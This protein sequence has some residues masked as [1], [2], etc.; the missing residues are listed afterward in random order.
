MMVHATPDRCCSPGS[1]KVK[2]NHP[3]DCSKAVTNGDEEACTI[4]K[5][6]EDMCT[7]GK[8]IPDGVNGCQRAALLKSTC[9]GSQANSIPG[10]SSETHDSGFLTDSSDVILLKELKSIIQEH[11]THHHQYTGPHSG[12][13]KRTTRNNHGNPHDDDS[14]DLRSHRTTSATSVACSVVNSLFTRVLQRLTVFAKGHCCCVANQTVVPIPVCSTSHSHGYSPTNSYDHK[15]EYS[16]KSHPYVKTPSSPKPPEIIQTSIDLAERGAGVERRKMIMSVEGMDCPS[17]AARVTKALDTIPSVTQSKVNTF[18]AEATLMY[19]MGTISPDE[20]AQRVTGLTGFTCKLQQE[21]REEDLV[22]TLWI[23]V[24]IKWDDSEL[25][26]GVA[27]KSRKLTKNK[28]NLLEVQYDSTTIQPRDVVAAFELWD[29]EYVPLEQVREPSQASKEL[30]RLLRRTAL[31]VIATIPIL[32]FAWAPLPKHPILYGSISLAL[33]TFV[34]VYVALPLYRSSFHSLF[35]QRIIDM[36]LLVAGSTSIA[37]AYSIIS[38]GFLVAGKPIDESF[39][40]TSSLLVT[41]IMVGD[42]VS[43]FARRRT[44]SALDAVDA[45]QVQMVT[46]V[47]NGGV[48][49]IPAELI[50]V[51]DILQVSPDSIIPTDGVLRNGATQV[52]ESSLTGESVPVEKQ[53]GSTVIAG[54]LNLSGSIEITVS[55]SLS[56][57][58]VAGIS[59]LMHDAQGSRIPIQD[60]ADKVAAYFAPAILVLGLVTFLVWILIGVVVKIKMEKAGIRALMKMITVLVVSCPCAIS[61][62]VPMV[63][64]IAVSVAAKKGVLF[65]SIESVQYAKDT[66]AVLFDKTGTLTE[67]NLSVVEFYPF[68]NDAA[69]LTY[70]LTKTSTH[71]VAKAVT[72]HVHSLA[73]SFATVPTLGAITSVAGQGLETK[74]GE[75]MLRGGNCRWLNLGEHPSVRELRQKSRTIFAVTLDGEPV[76]VFGLI[77][78]LRPGAEELIRW[79]AQKRVDVYI[80]SGDEPS[81]VESVATQLGIQADH[82][83]GGCTPKSKADFVRTIQEN[84]HPAS[85]RRSKRMASVMFIGDGTNDIVALTQ[86]DTGVSISSGT[87]V[88]ISA[89]DVIMLNPANI[90]KSVKTIFRVSESAFRRIVWNFT[91]SFVYNLFAILLAA[92]AFVKFSIRPE[93]AGLGE[94]VS[95]VPVIL[96]AWTMVLI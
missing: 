43:A 78:K 79:L 70:H 16:H 65:K 42:L 6:N 57:N 45:L 41:L 28:G 58:T 63:V 67:G 73:S 61:L 89:A 13:R 50:H 84:R 27:I 8:C 24:P 87:D 44:T 12:L 49:T 11:S 92:G 32:I 35:L 37:Y 77:D 40:E 18:A 71:P 29:G 83:V 22:K 51:G 74:F 47:E 60:L 80:L 81:A 85:T 4:G 94:M 34:Q 90:H 62:C 15:N 56:E 88:A 72:D 52:D 38:F 55:R 21:L 3:C 1:S 93:Y 17:C 23:S 9:C 91:W 36:D 30:W 82:A 66:T 33:A 7:V 96:V 2:P 86:A 19:D 39:F 95:I 26:N 25:P 76:A 64:V 46:L 68:T 54:T 14:H 69:S 75:R 5:C 59:R 20:I 48:R 31:S 53:R 10:S